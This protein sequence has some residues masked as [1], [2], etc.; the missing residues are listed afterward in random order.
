MTA[1][2]TCLA[3]PLLLALAGWT[4]R[5]EAGPQRPEPGSLAPETRFE[6]LDGDPLPLTSLRGKVVVLDFWASWCHPC[7]AALPGLKEL[8][9]GYAGAPFALVS[10]SEDRHG[11]K[12]REFVANHELGW[13]QCW[14]G[15]GDAQ[16]LYGVRA[17][18][19]YFVLDPQGRILY[20]HTG[21]NR[22]VEREMRQQIDQAIRDL[23]H[24]GGVPAAAST[25]R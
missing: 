5:P 4:A 13:T 22:G 18:P 10:V 9:R 11:G 19:T 23:K 3:A 17:Y 16:R 12:L 7:V 8:A 2:W 25:A 21:W 1:A 14:D 24:P 15:N 6:T 20:T